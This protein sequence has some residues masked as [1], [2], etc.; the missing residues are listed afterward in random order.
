M[1]NILKLTKEDFISD[2]MV[3]WCPGCGDHA[4]LTSLEKIM[5]QLGKKKEDIL[6]ISGIGCSSRSPYYINTYGFHG[7]HGRA[8]PIASGAKIANPNLSVWVT[9]GDGDCLAIGGNHFIHTIRRN[10]DIK[11]VLFNNEIYGLT[12]GQYS[13]TT[14][15]GKV[16]KTSP[17]GTIEEPFNP[18]ELVIGAGGTFFARSM[19][20]NLKTQEEILL[21]ASQH[22]G[23]AVTEILQNCVIFNNGAHAYINDREHRADRLIHLQ[24]G[25][26]MIFGK[27]MNKGIRLSPNSY[28]LEVVNIGENDI[29]VDDLLVH[30]IHQEDRGVHMMLARMKAPDFP[31]A[32]GV[33]R[34]VIRPIYSDLLIEQIVRAK[35]SSTITN[36]D[37]LMQSGNTWNVE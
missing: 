7:I 10:M 32:V 33:I 3:K 11:I 29:T 6:I 17:M 9:T 4:I 28:Q 31:V 20:M 23:T 8:L 14:P 26:P 37:E 16:T 2:Q 27:E 22:R 30:D 15:L 24:H 13:P 34:S 18:G 25:K 19:D 36:A 5:P 1:E 21:A 35:N 12:K